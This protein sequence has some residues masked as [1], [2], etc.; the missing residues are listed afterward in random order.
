MPN[1]P[2]NDQHARHAGEKR[3]HVRRPIAGQ[4]VRALAVSVGPD[5]RVAIINGAVEEIED[6]AAH[7]RRQGHGAPVLAQAGHAERVSHKA[8]VDAEEEAVRETG[9]GADEVQQ[10]RVPDADGGDLGE[11]EGRG[12]D[13]QAPEA[14]G[15]EAFHDQVAADA[16]G[17]AA[18]E[19]GEGD[20]GD[21]VELAAGDERGRGAVVVVA[22]EGLGVVADVA[23]RYG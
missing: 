15:V 2:Q 13:E 19:G 23:S 9:E 1:T 11:A 10:V 12:R 17:E 20:D 3:H 7:H 16:G 22:P 6:V 5:D 4:A 21:V 8:G 14:A 18:G